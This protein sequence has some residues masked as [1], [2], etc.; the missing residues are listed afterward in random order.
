VDGRTVAIEHLSSE[1]NYERLPALAEEL[2][3][4]HVDV[5]VVPA[6][7]NALAVQKATRTIPIVMI[8]DPER[9]GLAASL[10][11]PGGNVT[12]LSTYVGPEI[13]GKQLELLKAALPQMSRVAILTNPTNPAH[14]AQLGEVRLVARS[15]MVQVQALE[16]R[17]PTDFGSAFAAMTRGHAEAV[18][19]LSD[20]MFGIHATQLA[21][22]VAKNRLPAMAPRFLVDAGALMSYA[23][24]GPEVFRRA[25]MYADRILKGAKPGDL[26]VEQPTK[27]EFVVN[28][29]S[30]KALGLTIPRSLLL[31]ADQVLQ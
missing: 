6:D 14:V 23:V 25:A 27:F 17:E 19:I 26:P 3:R 28:L 9:S 24:N 2:V 15:L 18:H 29:K 22:L 31:R 30:A 13:A 8:G 5:I 4:R 16:A 21:D 20:G 12:G 11:R 7:Q 10:A 1:G